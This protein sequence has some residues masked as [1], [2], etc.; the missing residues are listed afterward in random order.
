[1]TTAALTESENLQLTDLEGIIEAGMKTF[2]EVGAA[3]R[4][5]R[6]KRLYRTT[7][8]TF[9][10]YCQDRWD[11]SRQ[12]ASQ[13]IVAADVV[14]ELSTVVDTPPT[15]ERQARELGRVPQEKRAEVWE[16][17]VK[18]APVK[19]GEPAVTAQHVRAAANAS[20]GIGREMRDEVERA[21]RLAHPRREKR[22]RRSRLQI[23]HDSFEQSMV[24]VASWLAT[25]ASISIP[26]TLPA[27]ER[28]RYARE[29]S[30]AL[31]SVKNDLLRRINEVE[32]ES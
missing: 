24:V 28:R 3:I 16:T 1:M 9:E 29:L 15:N 27:A 8:S 19:N 4:L 13:L 5:I 31:D 25:T 18:S 7:H 17:A 32:S 10:D 2:V 20:G 14:A 23:D 26:A 30:T 21:E 6:D 22:S 12:R 11:W